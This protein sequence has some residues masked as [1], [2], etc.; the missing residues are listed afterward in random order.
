MLI[1]YV[2]IYRYVSPSRFWLTTQV[3]PALTKIVK[4]RINA[5]IASVSHRVA[6]TTDGWKNRVNLSFVTMT[7]RYVFKYYS[8]FTIYTIISL[9][10]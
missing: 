7:G 10:Y 5:N 6:I 3:L 1:L 2:C 8:Y 4:A 9:A